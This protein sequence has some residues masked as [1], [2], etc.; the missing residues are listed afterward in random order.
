MNTVSPW[1]INAELHYKSRRKS[2]ARI[3]VRRTLKL[4]D[5]SIAKPVELR[6]PGATGVIQAGDGRPAIFGTRSGNLKRDI[7][8]SVRSSGTPA[9]SESKAVNVRVVHVIVGEDTGACASGMK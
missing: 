9:S 3:F 2:I 1:A 6:R 8:E 5:R 4:V 7:G